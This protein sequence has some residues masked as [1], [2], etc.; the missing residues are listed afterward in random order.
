VR[1]HTNVSCFD[2][3]DGTITVDLADASTSEPFNF[4]LFDLGAGTIV[5]FLVT[6]T[7][8][9]PGRGVVYSNVPPGTYSVLFFKASCYGG[10]PLSIIEPPFGFVITEPTELIG[11]VTDIDP[12]CNAT[13][14]VGNGQVDISV[15]GGTTP[16]TIVWSG[17]TTVSAGT[18]STAS[19]LD[20]GNYTVTITDFNSCTEVLNIVVP[21]TTP[22]DAGPP[23]GVA[24]GTNSFA[25]SGNAF[26][27]GEIGTWTGPA[28][29]TFSPNANTPNATANNLNVGANVLTWTITDAGFVC[30]GSSDNITVTFSNVNISGSADVVL[31]CFGA[32][33][34]TGTFTVTGGI[35][36]FTY[37]IVSNTAGATIVLPAPGPTT[38]VN[39]SN[40]GA[41]VVTLQVQD[42]SGCTDQVSI[43]ITQPA[44]AITITT[45]P[46]TG[47]I[48]LLCNGDTNGSGSFT[49]NGGTGAHTF[50][51]TTNTTG[52][53]TSIAGSVLSF[54]GAG[55]GTISV[56]V[57]DANNCLQSSS[58][59]ITAPPAV[60]LTPSPAT[61]TIALL[62]NGDTN[63]TGSFIASGGTGAHT[64]TVTTNTTGGTTSIVGSV[65]SFTGAG[66]GTISVDVRDANNC[67]QSSSI[68]ITAP[69]ALVL[70]PSPA[71]GTIALLCNSDTNGAGSFT[72]SGGTGAHTFTVTTNTTGGT[73]SI[74]GSVLSFTGAGPGTISVDVRDANN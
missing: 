4:E 8:N 61:G 10:F 71:T 26:A 27:A 33:S 63:G 3:N 2:A 52:G 62:C 47:T 48:S 35:A 67:L 9:K 55:A 69:P 16:Y 28:G 39:F 37:S 54:T 64:F 30:P 45:S 19:N 5:T 18:L 12:D 24:C 34:G 74:A 38:S 17:P 73:T 42:N 44:S 11:S 36:P 15:S 66:V 59:T 57:R 32:T 51:V 29:V 41:G 60:V 7:E 70:T 58:I 20:A 53:T 46:V 40:A 65:L 72:A 1:T 68:T 56:D 50:T 21:V 23:T 14:G 25:L 22:A 49:A 43:N 6:E 13:V 31:L